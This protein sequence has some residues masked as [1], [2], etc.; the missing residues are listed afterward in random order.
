VSSNAVCIAQERSIFQAFSRL[1][2]DAR[3]TFRVHNPKVVALETS[4]ATSIGSSLN[5]ELIDKGYA[6][7]V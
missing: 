5:Q 2:F 7:P 4:A 3:A 6:K 1:R